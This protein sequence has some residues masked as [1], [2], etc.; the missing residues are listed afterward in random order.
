V[1]S[2]AVTPQWV[3]EAKA[4]GKR[5]AVLTAYDYPTA[6]LL[7]EAGIPVILVG[8]SLGMVVLGYPDTTRVTLPEM[9]HHVG[10]VARAVQ[11]ALVVADLPYKSYDTTQTALESART[12]LGAGARAV[13]LEGGL[14]VTPQ[15]KAL[16]KA[17]IPV[18]GHIGMLPQRIR[19][20]GSYRIKGRTPEEVAGLRKDAEALVDAG[21]FAIVLECVAPQL[22]QELS[23][24]LPV[25]TIGIGS[26]PD[27]DG[28]VRVLYDL[29]GLFPWFRPKFVRPYADLAGAIRQAV[30]SF[31]T[32]VEE[33]N[34]GG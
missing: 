28:Q 17:G 8:D 32:E 11:K 6:R 7:D 3:Q 16:V 33:Q 26:G 4:K 21:V 15:V 12:L 1:N 22:A 31:L 2:S 24:R 5:L 30:A 20:E 13:K 14:T 10:A 34:P 27:C 23:K 29:V 18:M 9:V 19:E 25:P